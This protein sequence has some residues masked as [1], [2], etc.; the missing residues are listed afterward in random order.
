MLGGSFG[1][2][3]AQAALA[4]V[5][6]STL[7][8]SAPDINPQIVLETGATQLRDVFN[9]QEIPGVLIAYMHGIKA[10]FAIAIGMAGIAF[11]VSG[12]NSWKRLHGGPEGKQEI[13]AAGV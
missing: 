5:I 9:A 3:A 6:I 1:L 7:A 11:I 4:N 8:T 10:T 12:M 2:S 13:V